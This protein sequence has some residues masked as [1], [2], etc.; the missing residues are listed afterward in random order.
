MY[1]LCFPSIFDIRLT[2]IKITVASG[3][4]YTLIWTN[5]PHKIDKLFIVV[6]QAIDVC[7][8]IFI[9]PTHNKQICS[10]SVDRCTWHFTA[11]II[12][13][14]ICVHVFVNGY[15]QVWFPI[16]ADLWY[17]STGLLYWHWDNFPSALDVNL[18]DMG[19]SSGTSLA[20]YMCLSLCVCM[21]ILHVYWYY[22]DTNAHTYAHMHVHIYICTY[23]YTHNLTYVNMFSIM[24][25]TPI[26]YSSIAEIAE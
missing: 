22:T 21:R 3:F 10:S 5:V 18:E 23:K 6:M 1:E 25:H 7:S 11:W 2:G 12:Y 26:K 8:K 16:S 20:V 15:I 14:M 17:A 9:P 4:I 19:K 24:K 13:L